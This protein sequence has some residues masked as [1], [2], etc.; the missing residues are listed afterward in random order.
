MTRKK[1]FLIVQAVLCALVAGLLAAAALRLYITGAAKQAEGDLF[2]YMFTRERAGAK[3]LPVL[4]LLCCAVGL[5]VAGVLLG[6]RD[7][8][9]D[10]PVRDEKLLRD[11]GS[12]QERAVHQ[13]ADR[14]TAILRTA[15]LVIALVLIVSGIIN[16]GLEDVLAKGAA[17]CTECVGL[18]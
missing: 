10:K 7:E 4:P 17:V 12:I 16:G 14:K 18:G 2:Y 8:N 11:L 15:V 13:Q 6:I 3:L 1:I 5:T 9:E